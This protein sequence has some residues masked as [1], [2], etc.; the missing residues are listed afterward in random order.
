[1]AS[2]RPDLDSA[3]QDAAV[4]EAMIQPLFHL[5]VFVTVKRRGRISRKACI[6]A[7]SN[8]LQD[9]LGRGATITLGRYVNVIS[10]EINGWLVEQRDE[11]ARMAYAM[12]PSLN[13]IGKYTTLYGRVLALNALLVGPPIDLSEV[14]M[15]ESEF[16][17]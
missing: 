7:G 15:D 10:N 8:Y 4:L 2:D 6:D 14:T 16:T 3:A 17:Q 9:L 5:W 1:M 11:N 12:T 13:I